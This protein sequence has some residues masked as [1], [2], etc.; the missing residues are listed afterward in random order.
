MTLDEPMCISLPQLN[1]NVISADG[2]CANTE[3][4]SFSFFEVFPRRKTSFFTVNMTKYVNMIRL[5]ENIKQIV[6]V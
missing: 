5:Q 3:K 1:I 6:K 4:T 2:V